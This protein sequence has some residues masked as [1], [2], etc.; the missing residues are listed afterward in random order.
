MIINAPDACPPVGTPALILNSLDIF[1]EYGCH[2]ESTTKSLPSKLDKGFFEQDPSVI[3]II[4]AL[5]DTVEHIVA[6]SEP[7]DTLS[8]A[9]EGEAF[10]QSSGAQPSQRDLMRLFDLGLRRLFMSNAMKDSTVHI[11][12]HIRIRSLSTMVPAVFN[13]AYR[14]VS[15]FHCHEQPNANCTQAMNQRTVSIP[16]ITKALSSM[17]EGNDNHS[18]RTKVID[19]LHYTESSRSNAVTINAH[20]TS[21]RV[22]IHSSLWH[23]A[24]ENL[25]TLTLS[26]RRTSVLPTDLPP[27]KA[28]TSE[29]TVDP[30]IP[31][32]Q[33]PNIEF[34]LP[35]HSLNIQRNGDDTGNEWIA[36]GIDL[37]SDFE[38]LSVGEDS[39]DTGDSTQA[40]LDNSYSTI[41]SSRYICTDDDMMFNSEYGDATSHPYPLRVTNESWEVAE[42]IGSPDSDLMLDDEF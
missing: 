39:P 25:Q 42:Y 16:K 12:D 27:E 41:S 40:F 10:I 8:R 18:I 13:S 20:P 15:S 37:E 36:D 35:G 28:L 21:L 31:H 38:A 3:A 9:I 29:D 26:S 17:I 30:S 5:D 32:H 34:L 23:V 19:L 14:E 1:L 24:Q 22:A 4:Q 2:V 11:S 33:Q 7:N 6:V